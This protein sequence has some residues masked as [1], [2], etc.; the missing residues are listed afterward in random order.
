MNKFK[1]KTRS[2]MIA[3]SIAILSSAAVVSTGFAAWVISGGDEKNAEGSIKADTVSD[4]SHLIS[5]LKWD[6]AGNAISFGAPEISTGGSL[7]NYAGDI[8]EKL[9]A[10]AT[11]QVANLEEGW[12]ITTLFDTANLNVIENVSSGQ[13]AKYPTDG[14][15]V[16]T[17]PKYVA[18]EVNTTQAGVYL[19]T[20]TG[21]NV[22]KKSDSGNFKL[23]VVFTWGTATGKD[24]PFVYYNS[25]EVNSANKASASSML[26]GVYNLNGVQFKLTIKTK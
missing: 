8:R 4:A 17:L 24:N 7:L 6:E 25:L 20:E 21:T 23:T 13:N 1:K 19:N 15:L 3:A 18:G 16:C 26:A 9:T 5:N 22:G 10:S 11:F 14:T 2:K 12:S